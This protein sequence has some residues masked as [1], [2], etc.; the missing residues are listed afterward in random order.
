MGERRE[1]LEVAATAGAGG[2]VA[3]ECE[4][5]LDAKSVLAQGALTLA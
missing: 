3:G 1:V 5:E 2:E 4:L